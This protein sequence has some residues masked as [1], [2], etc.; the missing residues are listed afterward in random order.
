[1]EFGMMAGQRS[2]HWDESSDVGRE[3]GVGLHVVF[4]LSINLPVEIAEV[5]HF[6]PNAAG[7][8]AEALE[9]APKTIQGAAA[10]AT[11]SP[12]TPVP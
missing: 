1:M 11:L 10:A 3:D 9:S 12:P 5:V 6:Y 2:R 4:G 8:G 7:P